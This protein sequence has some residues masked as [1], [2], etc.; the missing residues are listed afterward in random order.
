MKS[1]QPLEPASAFC[2]PAFL[3]AADKLTTRK[4]TKLKKTIHVS[5]CTKSENSKPLP[6]SLF[7]C[8]WPLVWKIF[9]PFVILHFDLGICVANIFFWVVVCLPIL[10]L[11]HWRRESLNLNGVNVLIFSLLVCIFDVLLRKSRSESYFEHFN[12][13]TFLHVLP[14]ILN[15]SISI[16]GTSA[17]HLDFVLGMFS[18]A[19]FILCGYSH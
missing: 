5:K 4:T 11:V 12:D 8:L 7:G 17:I 13:A 2:L 14:N 6:H 15:S 16:Y 19:W 9:L 1:K 10:F 3:W 18:S